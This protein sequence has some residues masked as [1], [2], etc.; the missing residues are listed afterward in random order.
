MM[1]R[2]EMAS[3]YI[4]RIFTTPAKY[5]NIFSQDLFYHLKYVR[6]IRYGMLP[7][8]RF[9]SASKWSIVLRVIESFVYDCIHISAYTSWW[10]IEFPFIRSAG[11]YCH[12][13]LQTMLRQGWCRLLDTTI[14][15]WL[16]FGPTRNYARRCRSPPCVGLAMSPWPV[17]MLRPCAQ[18]MHKWS[19]L[20][21]MMAS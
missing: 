16:G 15:T 8:K 21:T 2:T 7:D 4:S 3:I 19:F 9:A 14:K 5:V 6:C 13:Q 1:Y 20:L 12:L 18:Y 11:N 17:S 10:I